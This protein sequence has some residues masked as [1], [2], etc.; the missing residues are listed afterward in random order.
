MMEPQRF[1]HSGE[2]VLVERIAAAIRA[3]LGTAIEV[4][5]GHRAP[6]QAE[7][8]NRAFRAIAR[9]VL[10]PV[11]TSPHD[12]P[13]VVSRILRRLVVRRLEAGG[14]GERATQML[15]DFEPGTPDDWLT[16]LLLVPWAEVLFWL[17]YEDPEPV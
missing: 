8:L 4:C 10:E 15:L 17:T 12:L 1:E 6:E 7:P 11:S 14:L 3:E 9:C 13:R 16:F 2:I 5:P